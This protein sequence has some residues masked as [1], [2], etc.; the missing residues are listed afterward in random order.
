MTRLQEAL[1]P[2]SE[3]AKT[4]ALDWFRANYGEPTDM[5]KA[6]WKAWRT[7]RSF[8]VSAPTGS[9]K[10]LAAFYAALEWLGEQANTGELEDRVYFLYISPLKALAHDIEVNLQKPLAAICPSQ[11]RCAVRSGDTSASER[12]RML[13]KPPHILATTPESLFLLLT[14]DKSRQMLSKV[15]TVIIDELGTLVADKRGAHLA[16]SLARLDHL[17]Q[18]PA[19]RIGLS[20]TIEP[21]EVAVPLL[22][23]NSEAE[24]EVI[25]ESHV[26][27]ITVAI[28]LPAT[29]LGAITSQ[30]HWV[31]IHTRICEL[32]QT[33]R[34]LLVFANNRRTVERLARALSEKLGPALVA[35]HHGSMAYA[36]RLEAERRLRDGSA[37]IMVATASLEMGIDIGSIDAVLQIGA[38]PSIN[39]LL[40][41][42]GRCG[43]GPH[44]TSHLHYFPLTRDQLAEGVV[45]V[46]ALREGVVEP[47]PAAGPARD[48]LAQHLVAIAA[49]EESIS[50][51]DL[52]ALVQT[53][54]PYRN[55]SRRDLIGLLELLDKGIPSARGGRRSG[56]LRYDKVKQEVRS[57]QG[58]RMKVLT[59]AGVI[60]DQFEYDIV[61]QPEGERIGRVS[62]DF[63]IE[64]LPGEIMQFGNTSYRILQVRRDIMLVED[65]GNVP[66]SIP[67]WFGDGPSRSREL[68]QRISQLRQ[69]TADAYTRLRKSASR[70]EAA[71]K[72]AALLAEQYD[73]AHETALQL[74]TYL[75]SSLEALGGLPTLETLYFERFFDDVGDQHL[76]VHSPYGAPINRGWALAMRK[77]FCQQ[78]NFELQASALDDAFILSLSPVHSFDITAPSKYLSADTVRQVLEQAILDAPVFLT[79]WRWVA[80]NALAVLRNNPKRRPPIFQRTESEDLLA[81]VF[82]DQLACLENIRGDRDI[83]D[84]PLVS[85]A[86]YDCLDDFI[87]TSSL[88][89]LL[90]KIAGGEVSITGCDL[91]APSPLAEEIISAKPYAYLDDGDL[92]GRRTR[93]ISTEREDSLVR[94]SQLGE[95]NEKVVADIQKSLLDG[96]RCPDD[97]LDALVWY[98]YLPQSQIET[99]QVS[100][101]ARTLCEDGSAVF[102]EVAVER[103]LVAVEHL[104]LIHL[105]LGQALGLDVAIP[106]S[107]SL[108]EDLCDDSDRALARL[109]EL[110]LGCQSPA[111]SA[112]L[113]RELGVDTDR[114]QVA[115]AI[116]TNSGTVF[117]IGTAEE[118][119]L[120]ARHLLFRYRQASL[121]AAR[122]RVQAACYKCYLQM[123]AQRRTTRIPSSPEAVERLLAH[124]E[125]WNAPAAHWEKDIFEQHFENYRG[126]HLDALTSAGSIRLL[127]LSETRAQGTGTSARMRHSTPLSLVHRNHYRLALKL[128]EGATADLQLSSEAQQVLAVLQQQGA[129][130]GEDLALFVDLPGEFLER[131]IAEL[132]YTGVAQADNFAA[133][134]PAKRK[135][136]VRRRSR[137]GAVKAAQAVAGRISL[138]PSVKDPQLQAQ[139][140]EAIVQILVRRWGVV[141][142]PFLQLE[143]RQL[144]SW[145]QLVPVLRRLEDQGV[146]RGGRFID[147]ALGEQFASPET[148]AQLA[149]IRNDS[150]SSDEQILQAGHHP[151][152]AMC[153]LLRELAA[154]CT[155]DTSA[156]FCD[157][158][159]QNAE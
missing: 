129:S 69:F 20:A 100:E 149:N 91:N 111:A 11:V 42:A 40:Q 101:L 4:S 84:H 131:A 153:R 155:H 157:F 10:T 39:T 146:L 25:R 19:M 104:P 6:A 56:L 140:L 44:A 114:L 78:F 80:Q 12:A 79:R 151:E 96:I 31:E 117:D 77:K 109:A 152:A 67:F 124:F 121:R 53:S 22:A 126:E 9:G 51:G 147:L 92:D 63:A 33:H 87:D 125:L 66:P 1:L 38:C 95:L 135:S 45:A 98:G 68:S 43:R 145:S 47:T 13:K 74:A 26:K 49:T 35:A 94:F 28:E 34:T 24:V 18:N 120:C 15:Q 57:R 141:A 136:S 2:A 107:L 148:V 103:W 59:N 128:A 90:A 75:T 156:R 82:P 16:L 127:R 71:H 73:I 105:A 89:S 116:L 132:L 46:Q 64:S 60:P 130:F 76:V 134:R 93:N 106:E 36:T 50:L 52:L 3:P 8:V 85:Q 72:T 70:D 55:F 108:P 37:R 122:E 21:V 88:Q 86:L 137:R 138:R 115:A 65:A 159:A 158:A 99:L 150:R 154:D 139:D 48:V 113:A 133:Y 27:S 83:P 32:H 110:R 5:Q 58:S 112:D 123:L 29:P 97:L 41:R 118:P 144:P 30:Q 17:C 142:R 102:L 54:A 23:G 61:R 119:A 14:A 62:E 7:G 81:Q 143:S